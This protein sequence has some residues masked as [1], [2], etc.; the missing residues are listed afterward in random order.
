MLNQDFLNFSYLQDHK[1]AK[2]KFLDHA[3][4]IVDNYNLNRYT[5]F[6]CPFIWD[7]DVFEVTDFD[8]F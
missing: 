8:V 6:R 7:F 3:M 1:R 2:G 4:T 5:I